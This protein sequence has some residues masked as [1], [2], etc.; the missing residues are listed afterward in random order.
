MKLITRVI[1]NRSISRHAV[2]FSSFP[3]EPIS[4]LNSFAIDEN[5]NRIPNGFR[6]D[7]TNDG[8]LILESKNPHEMD[9]RITFNED[10]HEYYLD[11]KLLDN[12]CTGLV[13]SFFEEFDAD[14]I[15]TKMMTGHRRII[16]YLTFK[17]IHLLK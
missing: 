5:G 9:K 3:V 10:T 16:V 17:S 8:P 2:H 13:N 1:G 15:I 4:F 11:G 14:A 6:I 7:R 12:T